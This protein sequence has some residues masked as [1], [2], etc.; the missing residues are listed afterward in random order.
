MCGLYWARRYDQLLVTNC[1]HLQ[2]ITRNAP[3]KTEVN[4]NNN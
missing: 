2:K 4:V 1:K 3:T